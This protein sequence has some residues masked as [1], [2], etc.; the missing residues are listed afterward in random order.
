MIN[1]MTQISDDL[2]QQIRD[3]LDEQADAAAGCVACSSPGT[4]L[5][6]PNTA[7]QFN[8]EITWTADVRTTAALNKTAGR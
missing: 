2:V 8:I 3:F 6:D 1:T 4:G 5:G 7:D